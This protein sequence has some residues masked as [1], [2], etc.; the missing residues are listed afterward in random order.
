MNN[1]ATPQAS[2]PIDA[3]LRDLSSRAATP[4][5]GSASALVGAVAAALAGMVG[6][7]NDKKDGMPGPL[8]E[9]IAAADV[10]RARLQA[11]MDEDIAAFIEL[12]ATW[13]LP[14]EP[15]HRARKEAAVI[16]ATEKPLEIMERCVEVLR[17][18]AA[19]LEK[20]KKNCLSDA[21]VSGLC[22]HAAL[23][24]AR[25]NVMINLP[26]IADEP[27]RSELR[28]RADEIRARAVE[29]RNAIDRLL[30]ANYT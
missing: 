12:A 2:R 18:A 22:A 19:G 5:G 29:L 9:T 23:E 21:G 1:S 7:L 13:K 28:R 6:R 17:L 14:D 3:F 25:L 16:A 10:L 26:G 4:G 20:S 11:L 8:H 15:A 30:E 27:R 24:S